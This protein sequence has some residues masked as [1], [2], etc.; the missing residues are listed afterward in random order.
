MSKKS[1]YNNK[2]DFENWRENQEFEIQKNARSQPPLDSTPVGCQIPK[3][4]TN[5][6]IVKTQRKISKIVRTRGSGV[7][8]K[9]TDSSLSNYDSSDDR[10]NKNKRRDENKKHRKRKKQDLSDSLLRDYDSSDESDYKNKRH[11]KNKN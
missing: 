8:P 7:R 5:N 10:K 6:G 1:D 2:T 9:F 11:D 3:H 4:N